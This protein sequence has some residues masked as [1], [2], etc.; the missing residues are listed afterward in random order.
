MVESGRMMRS[1]DECEMS[2]SC[3][4]ATFSSAA[5][6]VRTHHARQAADLLARDRVALVRH[7]RRALLLLAEIFFRLAHF[8]A[9]QMANLGGDLVQCR[10]NDRQALQRKTHDDRAGSPATKPPP[11]SVPAAGK[12]SLRT[13]VRGVPHFPPLRTACRRASARPPSQSARYCAAS[14]NTN[15]PASAQT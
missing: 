8:G 15:S 9:L 4:S 12:S 11:R 7:G 1:T 14:P 3:H 10:G 13:P 5:C 6:A 2:R